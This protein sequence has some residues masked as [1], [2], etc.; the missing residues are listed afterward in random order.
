MKFV[1]KSTNLLV[2]LRPGLS[3]QPL[4]G[5]PARPTVSV[6]FKDGVA[7]VPDGKM[8]EMMLAHD[9]FNSDYV[10]V[11]TEVANRLT[12]VRQDSEPVHLMTEMKYGTPAGRIVGGS[13]FNLTPE[14]AQVVNEMAA[15]IAKK[16]LPGMLETTLKTIIA[17][18]EA[19]KASAAPIKVKGKPGRPKKI[20]KVEETAPP[21][22]APAETNPDPAAQQQ[23]A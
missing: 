2:V 1:S 14:M 15:E 5:T 12:S 17:S 3:A 22:A 16:M 10:A 21:A 7:E 11:N 9:G 20:V 19:K 18:H 8:T 4:T 6:R 13:K 23:A